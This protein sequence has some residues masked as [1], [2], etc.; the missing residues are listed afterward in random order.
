MSRLG[1]V[2]CYKFVNARKLTWIVVVTDVELLGIRAM[3]QLFAAGIGGSQ[4]VTR[5]PDWVSVLTHI[6]RFL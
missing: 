6:R 2:S 1:T 3:A 5:G 4:S